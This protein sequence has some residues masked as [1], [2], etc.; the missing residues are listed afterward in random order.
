MI[1][2]MI[3]DRKDFEESGWI[4]YNAHDF[5]CYCM[6]ESSVFHGIADDITRAMDFGDEDD[7]RDALCAYVVSNG[8]NPAVCKYIR[9]KE[10]LVSA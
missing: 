9:S 2:D 8:Y 10:W 4:E 7:V 5:Y 3:L 6:E 1:I